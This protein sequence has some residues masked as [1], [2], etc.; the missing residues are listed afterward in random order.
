LLQ[1]LRERRHAAPLFRIMSDQVH[2][3]A[4]APHALAPLRAR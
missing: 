1:R 4:G 2:E 3:H